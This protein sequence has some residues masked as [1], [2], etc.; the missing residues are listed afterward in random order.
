MIRFKAL[1]FGILAI[2]FLM[3][4]FVVGICWRFFESGIILG[5]ECI[6]KVKS[7]FDKVR[8]DK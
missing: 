5:E 3:S 2:P 1:V 4:G 7:D 6:M 8:R